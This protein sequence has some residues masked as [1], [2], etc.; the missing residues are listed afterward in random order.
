VVSGARSRLGFIRKWQPEAD[1]EGELRQIEAE[2]GAGM[3]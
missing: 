1:A 2:R 3:A